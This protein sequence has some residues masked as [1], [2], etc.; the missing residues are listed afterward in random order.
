M[1]QREPD[2]DLPP[3]PAE[4]IVPQLPDDA[5]PELEEVEAPAVPTDDVVQF[6]AQP[7]LSDD[8]DDPMTRSSVTA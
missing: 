2:D 7:E 4:R 8:G 5:I 3:P 1:H 6:P